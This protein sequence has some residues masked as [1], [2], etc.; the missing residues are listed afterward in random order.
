MFVANT[1]THPDIFQ[2]ECVVCGYIEPEE[3]ITSSNDGAQGPIMMEFDNDIDFKKAMNEHEY[4]IHNRTISEITR[5]IDGESEY[6]V[7]AYLNT[8][9]KVLGVI[10]EDYLDHVERA[11]DYFEYIEDY[12]KCTECVAL[13]NKIKNLPKT[14]T[15]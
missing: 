14:K 9:E 2:F 13:E 12:E 15:N 4:E 10:E 3:D 5:A 11:R 8:K 1:T 6:I 7:I